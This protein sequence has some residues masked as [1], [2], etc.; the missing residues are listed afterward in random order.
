MCNAEWQFA[1]GVGELI[2]KNDILQEKRNQA[3]AAL[4]RGLGVEKYRQSLE[5]TKLN[6]WND[7]E[8][9]KL[10]KGRGLDTVTMAGAGV[11]IADALDSKYDAAITDQ[12]AA[13]VTSLKQA[14]DSGSIRAMN[15]LDTYNATRQESKALSEADIFLTLGNALAKGIYMEKKN[16]VWEN[17][18]T[19]FGMERKN[20]DDMFTFFGHEG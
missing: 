5:E 7:K 11:D 20:W 2:L 1:S 13:H 12:N 17:R 14:A 8:N 3:K 19:L 6:L 15:L 4:Q 9:Q 10:V 16:D 18:D